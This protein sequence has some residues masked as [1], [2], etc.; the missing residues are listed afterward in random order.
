MG[1]ADEWSPITDPHIA[2]RYRVSDFEEGKQVCKAALQKELGLHEDPGA[3]LIGFCGRLCFQKG[4]TLIM[5][6]LEWLMQGQPNRCQLIIMGKGEPALAGK[7]AEAEGRYRGRVCGYVGFD[8]H[9]E[10]RM[11]AGCD[12]LLMPSQYEPCGLP[13]MYAQMYGTIP[14]VHET[15]GLKDSVKGLWEEPRDNDTA[16]GFLFCNFDEGDLRN[17]LYRA[18]DTYH[19]RKPLFKQMQ[20]NAMTSNYYWPTAMDEY[21]KY[22]D[23]AM[24]AGVYRKAESWWTNHM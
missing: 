7:V 6:L 24:D 23:L 4:L 8:P 2:R 22:V 19:H 13:Q 16:T 18:V 14:V 9:V 1:I 17:K 12:L 15:G 10:H 3:C 21:E 11:M 20:E 5:S